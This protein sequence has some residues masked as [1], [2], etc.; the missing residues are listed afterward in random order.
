MKV[1]IRR[2]SRHWHKERDC[3]F[4]EAKLTWLSYTT[5]L[6]HEAKEQEWLF[7]VSSIEKLKEIVACY[8]CPVIFSHPK[9]YKEIEWEIDIYDDYI[10]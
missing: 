6:G 9:F 5:C 4:G 7:N 10:E 1:I 8:D 3:P 2:A